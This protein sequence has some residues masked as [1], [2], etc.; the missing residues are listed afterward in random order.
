M[1]RNHLAGLTAL[2]VAGG[3]LLSASPAQASDY[4][5]LY[6]SQTSE[7]CSDTGTGTQNN[8][9]CTIGAAAATVR[10]GQVV[11]I[12]PGT[13]LERVTVPRSGTLDLPITFQT[14][15]E[16]LLGGPRAG[17]VVDGQHDIVLRG[18]RISGTLDGPGLD[19]RNASAI[20]I[21]RTSVRMNP[22][23]TVPA[24]RLA[25]VTGVRIEGAGL[26]APE[27]TLDV[28]AAS[29]A[30][31]VKSSNL[32][33]P[34]DDEV[35][36]TVGLRTAGAGTTLLGNDFWGYSGAAV[37]IEPGA[38]ET[39]V[40]NNAV[41]GG[42]GHG[43]R[44]RTATGAAIANNLVR[45]RC[46]DGIRI[47][48]ASTGV[49]VQNNVLLLNGNA[50]PDHCDS[51]VNGVEIGVYDDAVK[52]TVVDYNNAYQRS[53]PSINYA[54]GGTRMILAAFRSASGQGAHD[55]DTQA[56][57]DNYDS[58]NAAAPG[59]QSTDRAGTARADDPAVP[60]TGAGPVTY[61]DRGP[62]ETYRNPMAR[63][64]TALDLGTLTATVDASTSLPGFVPITSYRID[65]GDGVVVTQASP[66]ATH[67]YAAPGDYE[68]S[69]RVTGSDNRTSVSSST[70]SVLR[71]T[72]TISLLARSNLRYVAPASTGLQLRADHYGVDSVDTFDL[73]DPG[74]GTVALYS[75]SNR[76][77]VA[78]F[79]GTQP[80]RAQST[81]VQQWERFLLVRNGDGSVSLRSQS[82]DRYVSTSGSGGTLVATATTIGKFEQFH[83]VDVT[84]ASRTFKARSNG[85]YV[86][87]LTTAASPL[88]ATA[89][90]VGVAQ[91]YDL[92]NLGNYQWA[93]FARA[94]NRFVTA[95][96][97]G[98]QPLINTAT[99][100]R[101]WERFV[102]V[103][104]SDGSVSLRS[105]GNSRYVTAEST[106]PL[107][108]NTT[109]IGSWQQYTLG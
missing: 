89:T 68:I 82:T 103:H 98:T 54:W 108:A 101:T 2:A 11:E 5:Y 105:T 19:V 16:P 93:L 64:D 86:T 23:A 66:R 6:V 85:R 22:A 95:A 72:G 36:D 10:A 100:P 106:K 48:G 1:R 56:Q 78:A 71:R 58:A 62:V 83:R 18:L 57:A 38:T 27:V 35:G 60:N 61:A 32:G 87:A 109:R 31:T 39:V 51:S 76:R 4:T 3:T 81:Q 9:F 7:F 63:F 69:V 107:I 79:V 17:F 74:D 13:Y 15:G 84:N 20:S 96:S 24:V 94:N 28:D 8:P 65:F 53:S 21:Q 40:A 52:G 55:R 33:T 97:L 50:G 30:V 73:A 75:R 70:V 43:V 47:E 42:G 90:G 99:V 41:Y 44:V 77:Y 80:M 104:N 49:S 37:S 91:R 29:S 14:S 12:G 88:A 26:S 34:N 46:R 67:R 25:A 59:Y 102:I 45:N 92:V